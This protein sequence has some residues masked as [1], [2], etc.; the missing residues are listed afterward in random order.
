[1]PHEWQS[2]IVQA[3]AIARKNH[4]PET[5]APDENLDRIR[6]FLMHE[7]PLIELLAFRR[8][9]HGQNQL[10]R[11]LQHAVAKA[12]DRQLAA[13][14]FLMSA[15][16]KLDRASVQQ[17]LKHNLAINSAAERVACII[18]GLHANA[19]F[20]RDYDWLQT[21]A[22]DVG[23]TAVARLRLLAKPEPDK[24][25]ATMLPRIAKSAK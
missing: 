13:Y 19:C 20:S 10:D 8:L 25:I 4:L 22:K 5:F 2:S 16:D 24:P 15:N 3:V 23:P 7:N 14:V 9:L 18:R 11:W 17:T 12:S 6:D 21:L 1:M